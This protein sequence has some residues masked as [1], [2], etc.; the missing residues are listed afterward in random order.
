MRKPTPTKAPIP[1][2]SRGPAISGAKL[3]KSQAP[4]T[5]RLRTQVIEE[6]YGNVPIR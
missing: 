4:A 5:R 1:P 2:K 6:D 3:L